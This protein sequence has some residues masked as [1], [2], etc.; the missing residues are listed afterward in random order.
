MAVR[1]RTVE[2]LDV[3]ALE[4]DDRV[5]I[6]LEGG[7]SVQVAVTVCGSDRQRVLELVETPHFGFWTFLGLCGETSWSRS[8]SHVVLVEGDV[9][10]GKCLVLATQNGRHKLARFSVVGVTS[11]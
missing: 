1:T 3:A 2:R 9:E 11:A 8:D 10:I 5:V 7:H 4:L 6:D